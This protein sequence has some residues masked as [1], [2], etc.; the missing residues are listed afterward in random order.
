[1]QTFGQRLATNGS[2]SAFRDR[3]SRMIRNSPTRRDELFFGRAT[4]VF[5]YLRATFL[6]RPNLVEPA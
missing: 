3:K 5:L 6:L 1:M 2:I 4:A